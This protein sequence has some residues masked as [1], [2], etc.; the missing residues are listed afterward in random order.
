M[1][2]MQDRHQGEMDVEPKRGTMQYYSQPDYILVRAKETG[3]FKGVRF[4]FL[5]YLHSDHRAIIAVIR[6]GREGR[7]RQ[8]QCKR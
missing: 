2:S 1:D 8:Y 5:Q 4:H 6:A 3:I 7:L